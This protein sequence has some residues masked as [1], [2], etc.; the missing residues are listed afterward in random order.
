MAVVQ[1]P[2]WRVEPEPVLVNCQNVKTLPQSSECIVQFQTKGGHFTS[3]VPS[4]H[5]NPADKQLH[6]FIIADVDQGV[7]VDI[8]AETLT[9]SS[10]ILVLDSEKD[11]LLSFHDWVAANGS[12]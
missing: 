5:V 6:A 2:R 9:S 8:P 1:I 3:F 11:S 7:L 10:R 12:Q 4:R